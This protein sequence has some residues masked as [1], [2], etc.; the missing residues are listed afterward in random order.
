MTEL[1]APTH[2]KTVPPALLNTPPTQ[3]DNGFEAFYTV[4]MTRVSAFLMHLGASPYEAA[5]ATHEAFLTLLPDKWRSLE[6][7]AAYLRKVAYRNYLR[8]TSSRAFPTDPVP[9][10]EGGTCPVELVILTDEQQRMVDLL[11]ALSPAER[12]AMAWNLDG[13][14]H[15][16]T[17]EI[18]GKNP[19]AVR[20]AYSRARA[21]LIHVLGL[22]KEAETNE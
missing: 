2:I 15:E 18:L 19:A 16:E 4:E 22:M 20:Q 21:R 11:A 14:S 7:P 12:E 9:D 6:H 3:Q 5:D 17:A 8:Q 10:R 1:P 13:F